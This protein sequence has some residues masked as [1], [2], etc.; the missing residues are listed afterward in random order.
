V[1]SVNY[2]TIKLSTG[3]H[4]SPEVGAC[5]MELASMLAGEPFTDHPESVCPVIGSFLRAYNDMVDDRR[6]QDLYAY[7]AKVVGST[8]C[9]AVERERADLLAAWA[10]EMRQRRWTRWFLPRWLRGIGVEGQPPVDVLGIHAAHSVSRP[11]DEQHAAALTL[12]DELL[13][14]DTI[15]KQRSRSAAP[16]AGAPRSGQLTECA[17]GAHL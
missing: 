6:R 14:T 15:S 8:R 2:Q 3:R 16:E 9:A 7:A 12:I 10:M 17:H 1:S 4:S 13:A 5:V 11:S